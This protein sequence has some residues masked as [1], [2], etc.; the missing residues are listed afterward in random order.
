MCGTVRTLCHLVSSVS[1]IL[2]YARAVIHDMLHL[3]AQGMSESQH[4]TSRGQTLQ[5]VVV[6]A[7]DVYKVLT[8]DRVQRR[9]LELNT[10][11]RFKVYAQD[12]VQRRF[13]E[14]KTKFQV[15]AQDRV[16]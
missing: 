4:H 11:L 6:L 10:R 14:L 16:Q 12:R 2:S 3:M 1:V 8:Q 9:L 7:M 15:F 13:L 5:F